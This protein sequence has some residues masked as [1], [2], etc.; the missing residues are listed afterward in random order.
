MTKCC[1]YIRHRSGEI[2]LT[3]ASLAHTGATVLAGLIPGSGCSGGK[4]T[5]VSSPTQHGDQ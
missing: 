1:H 2:I 3:V 4:S 5:T